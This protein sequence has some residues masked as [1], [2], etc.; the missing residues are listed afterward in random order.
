MATKMTVYVDNA[1]FPSS[2]MI[3]C[4][5]IADTLEELHTMAA[6]IGLRREWFQL[7]SYPH[8]DVSLSRR[9]E[10]VKR[11]AVELTQRDLVKVIRRLKGQIRC[12]VWLF[13]QR[14]W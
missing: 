12:G 13:G 2:R 10:A 14:P 1:R 8:Y 11:G 5:M 4:H 3:M 6:T 7:L 9:V